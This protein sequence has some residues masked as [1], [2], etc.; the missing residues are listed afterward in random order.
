MFAGWLWQSAVCRRLSAFVT[1]VAGVLI[2]R[3]WLVAAAINPNPELRVIPI[4]LLGIEEPASCIFS[5]LGGVLYSVQWVDYEKTMQ[6]ARADT[7]HVPY[8][9]AVYIRGYHFLW[10]ATCFSAFLFHWHEYR[11]NERADYYFVFLAIAWSLYAAML[12]L[13]RVTF[14]TSLLARLLVLPFVYTSVYFLWSMEFVLFDY[15]YHNKVCAVGIVLHA[16]AWCS[17]LITEP[18]SRHHAKWLLWGHLTIAACSSLEFFDFRPILDTFDGHSLWHFSG[19]FFARMFH[20]FFRADVTYYQ[21]S[22]ETKI[23]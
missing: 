2:G 15:G 8:P 10:A 11:W 22:V 17:L 20:Q 1:T 6:Q 19:L 23:K 3:A 21:H 7:R 14:T 12:R 13:L 9:Y 4:P 16:I 5:L 18:K